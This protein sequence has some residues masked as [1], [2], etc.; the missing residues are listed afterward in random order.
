MTATDQTTTPGLCG[1]GCGTPTRISAETNTP[2]GL[3]NGQP[4]RWINGHQNRQPGQAT[5]KT[6]AVS[7]LGDIRFIAYHTGKADAR[8]RRPRRVDI[9]D[10]SMI[11]ERYNAGYGSDP[12]AW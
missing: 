7:D 12:A 1:C 8:N 5:T 6:S 2:R 3:V 9:A 4:L 11:G 10:T